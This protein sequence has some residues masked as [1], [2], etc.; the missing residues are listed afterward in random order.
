MNDAQRDAAKY[1]AFVRAAVLAR[2]D[3]RATVRHAPS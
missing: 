1:P 2:V 3:R